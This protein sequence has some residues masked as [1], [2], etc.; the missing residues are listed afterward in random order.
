M[1]KRGRA[2]LA[3][4]ALAAVVASLT[5]LPAAATHGIGVSFTGRVTAGEE[6][7]LSCPDHYT[8]GSAE[9][10]FYRD[11]GMR[12]PVA[13]NVQPDRYV[14][15]PTGERT[16][17]AVWIVPRG[18]R[19]ATAG[20]SC[21]P[22]TSIYSAAECV[23]DETTGQW[24]WQ[25]N[26]TIS[27][28]SAVDQVGTVYYRIDGG[29]RQGGTPTTVPGNSGPV[30]GSFQ[31]SIDPTRERIVVIEYVLDTGEVFD[32]GPGNILLPDACPPFTTIPS[33]TATTTVP[34]TSTVVPSTTAT[35]T[36]PTTST[37][38]AP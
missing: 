26:Y 18:A 24:V 17:S 30:S 13:L 9:A 15:S 32:T 35:T 11:P 21:I 5:I 3:A 25:L 19:H 8:M 29:E 16:V 38:V 33:T 2:A 1:L 20:A 22:V 7:V 36:V 37:T 12:V 34:T 31:I 10:D 4:L 28:A 23:F 14:N 6:L 27:N